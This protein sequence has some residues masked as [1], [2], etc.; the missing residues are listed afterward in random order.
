MGIQQKPILH[1]ASQ[2][3]FFMVIAVKTY[4]L[5]CYIATCKII[6]FHG[7]DHK[8]SLL[9]CDAGK[10]PQSHNQSENNQSGS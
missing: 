7:N 5:A 4:N 9:G 1:V 8:E 2:K 3:T 6:D 10:N